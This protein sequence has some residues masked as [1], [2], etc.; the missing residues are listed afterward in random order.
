MAG[1]AG[2][3][4]WLFRAGF[5][6]AWLAFGWPSMAFNGRLFMLA[7]F[8]GFLGLAGFAMLALGWFLMAGL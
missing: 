7:C 5:R 2:L 1:F 8:A 4:G 6:L 3:F